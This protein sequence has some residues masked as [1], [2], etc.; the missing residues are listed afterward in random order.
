MLRRRLAP[1]LLLAVWLAPA[2]AAGAH[3][4]HELAHHAGDP[5]GAP[6]AALAALEHG[7]AHAGAEADHEHPAASVRALDSRPVRPELP[8]PGA[9]A[10]APLAIAVAPPELAELELGD[11]TPPP[12]PSGRPL[13]AQLSLLRI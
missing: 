13:L 11:P 8:V 12:R 10:E 4:A 7:H 5:A 3:T 2:A 1:L 9:A 6:D